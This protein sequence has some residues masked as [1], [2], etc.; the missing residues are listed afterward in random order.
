V[1][2]EHLNSVKSGAVD[3]VAL[4]KLAVD[5]SDAVIQ[6]SETL[7]D[8]LASYIASKPESSFLP[9]QTPE[10]YTDAYLDLYQSLL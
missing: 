8:S 9:Y 10:T 2:E 4:T 5:F 1:K 3:Y 6:G 7:H